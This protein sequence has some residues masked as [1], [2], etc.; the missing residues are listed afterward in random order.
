MI[1]IAIL[2]SL[3]NLVRAATVGKRTTYTSQGNY[4]AV[5]DC[6]SVE[7]PAITQHWQG[8]APGARREY[9]V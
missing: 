5:G 4:A 3:V 7:N 8:Y 2:V 1:R 9:V 6:I